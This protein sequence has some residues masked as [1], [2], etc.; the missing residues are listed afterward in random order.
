MIFI[1]MTT[2]WIIDTN[3]LCT[4]LGMSLSKSPSIKLLT[5]QVPVLGIR[6]AEGAENLQD[7]NLTNIGTWNVRTISNEEN[8][9]IILK[10]MKNFNIKILGVSEIH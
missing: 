6:K 10:D 7:E 2:V 5:S 3:L 8:V 4:A 1:A 9:D